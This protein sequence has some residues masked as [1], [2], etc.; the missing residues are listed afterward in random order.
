MKTFNLLL[1]FLLLTATSTFAAEGW[2]TDYEAA[3]AKAK[4][5]K[6]AVLLEFTGSDWCLPCIEMRKNVFSKKEFLKAASKDFILVE[7]DL[8]AGNKALK[9]KNIPYVQKH[10]VEGFP[11][12]VLLDTDKKEFHRFIASEYPTTKKFLAHLKSSLKKKL[13]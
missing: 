2:T 10:K 1:T 3:F 11:T 9:K 8:P 4:K 13:D 7:I 5:E 12:I 6:K